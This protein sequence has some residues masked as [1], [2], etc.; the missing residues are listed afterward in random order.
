MKIGSIAI[1]LIAE[2]GDCWPGAISL[3]GSSCST[4]WPAAA[5]Q[6]VSGARSPISPIPQLAVDGHANSGISRP[7]RRRPPPSLMAGVSVS[8][9][10]QHPSDAGREWAFGR[11]QAHDQIRLAGE[12]VKVAGMH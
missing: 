10:F 1:A 4:R 2:Y 5:S 11:Q 12:V 8:R 3:I 9:T 7:A 6:A